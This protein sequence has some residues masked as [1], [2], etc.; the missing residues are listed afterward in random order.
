MIQTIRKH[1]LMKVIISE[2]EQRL[3]MLQNFF[4]KEFSDLRREMKDFIRVIVTA[5]TGQV[6][7]VNE[8]S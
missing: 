3:D 7:H 2:K 1:P 5:N 6:S 4:L 8:F